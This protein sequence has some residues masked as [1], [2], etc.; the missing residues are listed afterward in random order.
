MAGPEVTLEE[1]LD[2]MASEPFVDGQA[3]CAL[4][5]ADWVMA[6]NGCSDPA[7]DLR[8]RYASP[9][10][11][12]KV[13]K[14]RGGF[15]AVMT[16]CATRAGLERTAKPQREDVGLVVFGK[17][18]TAAICLGERWAAKGDGL[19]VEKPRRVIAAWRV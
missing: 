19:V 6:R 4:T 15:R 17:R 2:R 3:D 11:R 5:V 14:G 8:G 10:G 16:L 9:S 13:L 12:Q 7:H 1:F 18:P